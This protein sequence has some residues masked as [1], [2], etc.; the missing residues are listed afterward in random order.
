MDRSQDAGRCTVGL[1]E[2]VHLAELLALEMVTCRRLWAMP[3]KS[4]RNTHMIV[5]ILKL[6][7]STVAWEIKV[8]AFTQCQVDCV[9]FVRASH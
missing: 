6:L 5:M 8:S 7:I 2:G 4:P 9:R 3:W 1:E